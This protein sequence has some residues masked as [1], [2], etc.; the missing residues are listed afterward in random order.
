MTDPRGIRSNNPLNI[1]Y[2]PK[3]QWQGLDS[4]PTD[5]RFCRFVEPQWGLRAGIVILRN[6][7]KR[8]LTTLLQMIS[9]WAPA[10]AAQISSSVASAGRL[11]SQRLAMIESPSLPVLNWPRP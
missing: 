10:N 2:S 6:Y 7:Q 8:G 9:T 11:V 1:E 5:G 4:P 3:T